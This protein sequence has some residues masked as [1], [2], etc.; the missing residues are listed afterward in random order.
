MFAADQTNEHETA[1]TGTSLINKV[2]GSG[3]YFAIAWV[4]INYITHGI[5]AFF[6]WNRGYTPNFSLNGLSS[7]AGTTGW[8]G[9]FIAEVFASAP[10]AAF[11]ISIIAWWLFTI[12]N[13]FQTHLRTFI[14]W[15]SLAAFI[16]Y[17]G[18]VLAGI[19]Y[20][21]TGI[22]KLFMGFVAMYTWARWETETI[23]TVLILQAIL[24]LAIPLLFV[25]HISKLSYSRNLFETEHSKNRLFLIVYLYPASFGVVLD[26]V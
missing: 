6:A 21:A 15:V 1:T 2:V 26:A 16:V 18:H 17:Y 22:S 24:S 8:C 23:T 10:I 12:T 5:S 11:F 9:R 19:A 25:P 20:M 3:L 4:G 7:L 13:R 14:L